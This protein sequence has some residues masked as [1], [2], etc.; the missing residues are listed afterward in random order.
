MI[1][2]GLP[3][4]VLLA[5]YHTA[6][7]GSPLATGYDFVWREEFAEGMRDRYGLGLPDPVAALELAFGS[8]RGL[9][10]VAPILLLAVWGLGVQL[11]SD[12]A[13]PGLVEKAEDR[14]ARAT[15]A[16]LCVAY[17]WL[18][19]AGYY[20]WDGGAS[21]GPRHMVPALPF[22]AL[23]LAPAFTQL[24]RATATLAVVSAAQMLL[25]AAAAPEA[26]QYGNVLWEYALPKVVSRTPGPA[27]TSTNLGLLVGLPSALSL[28]PL[29]G[30]WIW[31]LSKPT[32]EGEPD[33]PRVR[34]R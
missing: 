13:P 11:V 8:Y 23:G 26:T 21:A 5:A 27:V 2:G 18:L 19:N 4:A 3:F 24:P 33:E 25:L 17:Y 14:R 32:R 29:V 20:M 10:Y 22:L 16:A 34:E 7:F 31:G 28:A 30:L 1:A 9:F 12:H 6:A 15:V